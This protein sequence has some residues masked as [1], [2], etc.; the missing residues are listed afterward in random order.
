MTTKDS[1]NAQA[2]RV[3]RT[4]L[5]KTRFAHQPLGHSERLFFAPTFR[6]HQSLRGPLRTQ[7]LLL[8]VKDIERRAHRPGCPATDQTLFAST[9]TVHFPGCIRASAVGPNP[10]FPWPRKVVLVAVGRS[11]CGPTPQITLLFLGEMKMRVACL[12]SRSS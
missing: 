8:V 12:R 3:D 10:N 5:D 11:N 7:R 1:P 2:Y 9:P 4:R 6:T